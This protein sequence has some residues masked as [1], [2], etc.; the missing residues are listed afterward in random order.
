MADIEHKNHPSNFTKY[1]A[2]VCAMMV[3]L[4]IG[5]YYM[6]SNMYIY[7]SHHLRVKNPQL[8]FE[9]KK[10][11]VIM[12]IWLIVQSCTSVLSVKIGEK[13]GFKTLNFIAFVW[14]TL[15]NL[16]MVFVEN[17]SVY[18][19]V[20]G[21]SNGIAIG[22]GY[23]PSMY[24]AWTYFPDK[25]SVVTGVILFCAG[26][27]ASISSPIVTRIVNPNN[28]DPSLPE[29]YKNV[30]NLFLYL[31]AAYGTLTMIA[32]TLQPSPHQTVVGKEKTVIRRRLTMAQTTTEKKELNERLRG[33]SVAGQMNANQ[34]TDRDIERVTKELYVRE[35]GT[36]MGEEALFV[37]GINQD[38]LQDLVMGD[39]VEELE[40][41]ILEIE[42]PLHRGTDL[43][44]SGEQLY[45]LSKEL[46]DHSCP[47]FYY[48]FFSV[49]FFMLA[50]LAFCCAIYNY[51]LLTAWKQLFK[52]S[53]GFSDSALASLLIIGA[54]ANSSFRILVGVL[55]LKFQFK[56][57]YYILISTIV[58]TSFTFDLVV[59]KPKNQILGLVYLF[60]AFAGLGTTVTIFPTICVKVFGSEVGAKLYPCIYVCFSIASLASYLIYSLL[61][62][63]VQMFYI[64]G[65][66]AIL[67]LIVS[68]FFD[69]EPSWTAAIIKHTNEQQKKV[70]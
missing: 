31:T 13:I 27:S 49:T 5:S 68:I 62:D 19:A 41:H 28:V 33:L 57:F 7:V 44:N 66:F 46:Q 42:E 17:Y 26:M 22:L 38:K 50:T 2:L 69:P 1:R 34:L 9:G 48:G 14:F 53:L 4:M 3:N 25:K 30:P 29:V 63:P 56:Q 16:A 45:K 51:F 59:M 52:T 67:G 20:Y 23:L 47:S 6:Y 40:H 12:P 43:R 36:R 54:T 18:V 61:S 70:V 21:V 15:N 39:D 65:G 11:Q 32:C 37:T 24:T 55:L 10:V 60:L 58:F 64:F 35:F 8:D